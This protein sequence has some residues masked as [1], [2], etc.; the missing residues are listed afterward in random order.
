MKCSKHP[1]YNGRKKPKTECT[2]CLTIYFKLQKPRILPR[3]T[4]VERDKS[5][6]NRKQ[7][8]KDKE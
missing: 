6:Y 1:K 5:K 3:A 4:K 2:E 8:H 7:K